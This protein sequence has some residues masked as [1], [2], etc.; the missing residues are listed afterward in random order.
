MKTIRGTTSV[1]HI[2][3]HSLL[4][5][6][7]LLCSFISLFHNEN[8]VINVVDIIVDTVDIV[9]VVVVLLSWFKDANNFII[10]SV[11]LFFVFDVWF[12]YVISGMMSD[13]VDINVFVAV[14]VVFKIVFLRFYLML[15]LL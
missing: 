5:L 6:L 9:V 15:L 12:F 4:L 7:L 13:G 1:C 2:Q 8:I 14:V 10:D 11:F 3:H